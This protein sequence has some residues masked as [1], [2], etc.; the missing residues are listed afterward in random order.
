MSAHQI[1]GCERRAFVAHGHCADGYGSGV[2]VSEILIGAASG[3]ASEGSPDRGTLVHHHTRVSGDARNSYVFTRLRDYQE[4]GHHS[5]LAVFAEAGDILSETA[6]RTCRAQSRYG[7]TGSISAC[8][9]RCIALGS[10]AAE[11]PDYDRQD[12]LNISVN[13][14]AIRGP[15]RSLCNRSTGKC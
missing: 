3:L 14:S 6:R 5:Q 11:H 9:V 15:N 10:R 12:R 1:L 13:G 7:R 8:T 2:E 4:L